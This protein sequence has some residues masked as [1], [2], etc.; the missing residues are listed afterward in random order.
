MCDKMGME[1]LQHPGRL[2]S[3]SVFCVFAC[4]LISIVSFGPQ[5][6]P[7]EGPKFVSKK[8]VTIRDFCK[9]LIFA[10]LQNMYESFYV[11]YMIRYFF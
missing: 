2:A 3:A 5:T 11:I 1:I 8:V 4:W 7:G 10:T 9:T 6:Q